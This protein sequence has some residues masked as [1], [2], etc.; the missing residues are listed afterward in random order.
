MSERKHK[1][2]QLS[3][4]APQI[5][6]GQ[7]PSKSPFLS[8]RRDKL[9]IIAEILEVSKGGVNKTQIMYRANLS[10]TQLNGYLNFM[11]KN[12]L[13]EKVLLNDKEIYKSTKKGLDILQHYREITGS[14]GSDYMDLYK[15]GKK[16][17]VRK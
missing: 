3:S 15:I 9:Y 6:S 17:F 13:L 11:L 7:G 5:I 12:E 2:E 16:T 1:N 8:Q 10:F 14:I 4:T